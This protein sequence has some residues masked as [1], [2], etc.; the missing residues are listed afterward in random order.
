[1]PEK[2]RRFRVRKDARTAQRHIDNTARVLE[3]LYAKR[4]ELGSRYILVGEMPAQ[5]R[6]KLDRIDRRIRR[7]N[8]GLTRLRRRLADFGE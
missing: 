5:E 4:Q 8:Y 2:P 7:V 6:E 3:N 1:M